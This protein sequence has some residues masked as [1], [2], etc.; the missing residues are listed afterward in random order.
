MNKIIDLLTG[1]FA[2]G[3]WLIL[4]VIATLTACLVFAEAHSAEVGRWRIANVTAYCPCE[5]CCDTRTETT[6]NGTDTNA[7]PY[8][9]AA[10]KSIPFGARISVPLGLGVLDNVRK[11]NRTFI[12]D[13]RGGALDAESKK[14]GIL[15]L[16]LRVKEHSWAVNFGRKTIPVFIFK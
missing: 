10:D 7:A 4:S 6:A 1:K 13:D 14:Y 11:N 9:F 5:K 16:D 15:R 2:G 8:N 3:I 12:V